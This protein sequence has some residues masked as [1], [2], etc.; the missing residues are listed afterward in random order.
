VEDR[1]V[2]IIVVVGGENADIDIKLAANIKRAAK[3]W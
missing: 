3:I 2:V 1:Q